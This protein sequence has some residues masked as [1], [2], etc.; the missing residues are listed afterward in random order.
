MELVVVMAII[1]IS[2]VLATPNIGAWIPNYRLKGA[3]REIVSVMRTAQIK[4]VSTNARAS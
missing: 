3:I 1:A 4:S 2:A